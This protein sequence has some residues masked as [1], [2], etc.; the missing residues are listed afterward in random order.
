[1]EAALDDLAGE[2]CASLASDGR[3]GRTIAIK[4]RL[5][6]FST[7]TRAR[8]LPDATNDPEVVREVARELLR[9][10]APSRPVRLLGV[11]VAGFVES[12]RGAAAGGAGDGPWGEWQLGLPPPLA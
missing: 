4:I 8:T 2:L 5:A 10:F 12:P 7:H 6:D 11:R 9:A 3:R 1:M